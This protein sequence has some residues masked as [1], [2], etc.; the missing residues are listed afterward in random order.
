MQQG[1]GNVVNIESLAMGNNVGGDVG[2][3][4]RDKDKNNNSSPM[5]NAPIEE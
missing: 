5:E 1:D 4:D 2:N 3:E